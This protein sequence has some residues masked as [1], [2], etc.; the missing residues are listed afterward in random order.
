MRDEMGIVEKREITRE[1]ND[2]VEEEM[3]F[4]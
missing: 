2:V 4:C 1:V 3:V